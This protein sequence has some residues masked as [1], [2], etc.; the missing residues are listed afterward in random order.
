MSSDSSSPQ[1]GVVYQRRKSVSISQKP[2]KEKPKKNVDI[3]GGDEVHFK[4]NF[5]FFGVIIILM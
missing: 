3:N 5:F 1:L 4:K 2:P